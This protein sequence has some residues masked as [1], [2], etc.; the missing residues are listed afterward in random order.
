VELARSDLPDAERAQVRF[1]ADNGYLVW[2]PDIPDFDRLADA[3]I[4]HTDVG[5]QRLQD[6]WAVEPAVR[7]LATQPAVLGMLRLLYGRR[8]IPFQTLNFKRGSEQKT[9]PDSVHFDTLPRGF[10]AG[11]WFALEDVGPEN[12]PLHSYP[13]SHRLRTY[14]PDDIGLGGL[15]PED[16]YAPYEEFIAALAEASGLHKETVTMERGEALIWTANLLHGGEPIADPE[17]TRYSQVVHHFFEG[18]RYYTPL[19]SDPPLERYHWRDVIDISTG[20]LV[21]HTYDGRAI[22][23]PDS[24]GLRGRA[25]RWLRRRARR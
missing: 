10:M 4:R 9:H 6:A 11:V 15:A 2:R 7:T 20:Q 18:C 1:F 14:D 17:S 25:A 5:G 24:T 21:P 8:P 16:R 12:G 13:G 3:I 22:E 19:Y 23:S